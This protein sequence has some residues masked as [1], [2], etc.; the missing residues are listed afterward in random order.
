MRMRAPIE[1]HGFLDSGFAPAPPSTRDC[2]IT[3]GGHHV[4]RLIRASFVEPFAFDGDVIIV[5]SLVVYWLFL[6]FAIKDPDRATLFKTRVLVRQT[7]SYRELRRWRLDR[8]ARK[9]SRD[10]WGACDVFDAF[11]AKRDGM[12]ARGNSKRDKSTTR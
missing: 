12:R 9:A 4:A 11:G 5:A 8:S 7:P 2:I 6:N 10:M 3:A 1:S